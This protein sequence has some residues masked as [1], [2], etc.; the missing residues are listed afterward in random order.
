MSHDELVK[1]ER[2]MRDQY[3]GTLR[4]LDEFEAGEETM[5]ELPTLLKTCAE[6]PSG[7]YSE[8]GRGTFQDMAD[9]FEEWSAIVNALT[10]YYSGNET[11]EEI[12]QGLGEAEQNLLEETV[13][14]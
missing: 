9:D 1:A 10:G 4:T 11:V 13:P 3:I 2:E 8:V 12:E 7:F 5:P 6:E 14:A